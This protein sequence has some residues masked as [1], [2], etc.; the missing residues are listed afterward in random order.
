MSNKIYKK[1]KIQK[2]MSINFFP[3]ISIVFTILNKHICT[4]PC[5]FVSWVFEFPRDPS[6]EINVFH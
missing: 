2:E 5:Y 4:F 6:I 1:E 3:V